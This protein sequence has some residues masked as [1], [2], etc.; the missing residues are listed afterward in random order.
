[1]PRRYV[2]DIPGESTA[3]NW[4]EKIMNSVS[5]AG[6]IY[7]SV[8]IFE[9]CFLLRPWLLVIPLEETKWGGLTSGYCSVHPHWWWAIHQHH[10]N[11]GK[12]SMCQAVPKCNTGASTREMPSTLGTLWCG[13]CLVVAHHPRV[14]CPPDT[15]LLFLFFCMT[16][17]HKS[18]LPTSMRCLK[19]YPRRE[20]M[21]LI[22][23]RSHL[24]TDAWCPLTP[25][26]KGRSL[27]SHPFGPS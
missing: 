24:H 9:V 2:T 18:H 13:P 25:K 26:A 10:R 21:K 7:V 4:Y 17:F 3:W 22:P 15:L 23:H 19:L 16:T 27:I 11:T 1:M 20:G 12:L 8:L 6:C 14:G 5:L